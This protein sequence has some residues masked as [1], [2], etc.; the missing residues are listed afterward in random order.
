M[1][2]IDLMLGRKSN[3]PGWLER[4]NLLVSL[5]MKLD[6]G[7]RACK[8]IGAEGHVSSHDGVAMHVMRPRLQASVHSR[9]HRH[10]TYYVPC[11]AVQSTIRQ[12]VTISHQCK[13]RMRMGVG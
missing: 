9:S 10:T 3:Q 8:E 6:S 12:A 11:T 1:Q 4:G 5:V 7:A 13:M 2:A